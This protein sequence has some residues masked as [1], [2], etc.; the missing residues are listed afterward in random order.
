LDDP[1]SYRAAPPPEPRGHRLVHNRN[2]RRSLPVVFR[3]P[4]T[5]G[6][7]HA[8]RVEGGRAGDPQ[9]RRHLE[10]RVA[11][12]NVRAVAVRRTERIVARQARRSDARNRRDAPHQLLVDRAPQ[13]RSAGEGRGGLLPFRSWRWPRGCRGL[14]GVGH[15]EHDG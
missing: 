15:G 11:D 9:A 10:L 14:R 7:V 3:E 8:E 13:T 1:V 12:L 4:S 2:E 6:Q 5:A